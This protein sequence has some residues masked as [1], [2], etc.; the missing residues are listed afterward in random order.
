MKIK[1]KPV[2]PDRFYNAR[3]LS[4]GIKIEMEHT[5]N[6]LVAKH[7]TKN[8]LDEFPNYYDELLKMEKRMKRMEKEI[9][10]K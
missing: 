1:L 7:I 3:Q 4:I 2:K 5:N 9:R 8:H 10:K 6:K